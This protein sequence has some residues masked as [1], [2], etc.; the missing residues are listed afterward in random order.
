[1]VISNQ[2]RQ[3]L[4]KKYA[5]LVKTNHLLSRKVVSF[6][7]NKTVPYYSWFAYKEGF[8]AHMVNMFMSE[9]PKNSGRILDPFSGSGTTIFAAKDAGWDSVGIELMPI[10][11]FVLRS[12]QAAERV[13]V[14]ILAEVIKEMQALNFGTMPTNPETDLKHLT[15]TEKAFSDETRHKLNA[16]I[17]YI[18]H[19]DFEENL[20]QLLL[21]ASFCI[22]ERISFTRKDGQYLRWDTRA[23]KAKSIF[24]KGKIYNFE[25]ALFG[26]LNQILDDMTGQGLFPVV[27]STNKSDMKLYSGSCLELLPTL[28]TGSFDLVISSPPYCNRYDYTRTYALELIFLGVDEE[29]IR[30]LRQSLLTCTV[31]NKEKIDYLRDLYIRNEQPDLFDKAVK[32]FESNAALQEIIGI[33]DH[34]KNENK[35]NNK[36]ISR[37]VKNYFYEHAFVVFEMARLLKPGGRIYYVNDNVRYAGEIVPVDTILSEFAEKAG[38]IVK[39]IHNLPTGKGNSSQQMGEH[40]RE[41]VRKCVYHWEKP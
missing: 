16:Y 31:E 33:L 22:L 2:H 35:L 10:G 8:S 20:R 27:S 4:E 18:K 41:E 23:H 28:E 5:P 36:G 39:K 30:R 13:P 26:Q 7:G 12:R 1:M 21:F 38:L 17:N 14:Q 15:I 40:G 25:E 24:D 11:A 19:G 9:Y 3:A 29:E 6:Q 34:Y 32:A 37:M